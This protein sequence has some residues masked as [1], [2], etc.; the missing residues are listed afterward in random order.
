MKT[1]GNITKAGISSDYIR[2]FG[3][4]DN[5]VRRVENKEGHRLI[6]LASRAFLGRKILKYSEY[7]SEDEYGSVVNDRNRDVIEK[8]D[9]LVQELNHIRDVGEVDQ[10]RLAELWSEAKSTIYGDIV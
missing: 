7:F 10:E 9:E 5:C 3:T 4:V 2:A 8:L 6:K 1:V